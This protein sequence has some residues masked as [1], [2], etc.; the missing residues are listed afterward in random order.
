MPTTVVTCRQR[1][2][3]EAV[4][5]VREKKIPADKGKWERQWNNK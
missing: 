2:V 5:E 3:G 1:E 4:E